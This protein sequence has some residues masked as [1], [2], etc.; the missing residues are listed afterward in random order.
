MVN[1]Q[2][3]SKYKLESHKYISLALYFFLFILTTLSNE[4]M[5]LSVCLLMIPV[6]ILL[7]TSKSKLP[8]FLMLICKLFLNGQTLWL[9]TFNPCKTLSMIFSR[10]LNSVQ[11]S[12]LFM[13]G[14]LI[15]E[16]RSHKH[17]SVTFSS[18]CKWT[19]HV[20]SIPDKAWTILYLLR[21]LKF[22]VSRKSLEK[23]YISH[24]RPLL[25]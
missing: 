13:N 23:M 20:N 14:T 19:D 25:E 7:Y 22:R 21:V 6:C 1:F 10:K 4:L 16:T 5:A 24:I 2:N 18:T 12:S 3:G 17:L 11:H 15:E 8:G 9:V